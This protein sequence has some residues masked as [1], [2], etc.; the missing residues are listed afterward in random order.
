[1]A[2]DV[3]ILTLFPDSF[4]G[5]FNESI[6]Y[7]A[8]EKF[9]VNIRAVNVRD[10]ADDDRGTVD[11]RPFGGGPGMVMKPDTLY[12][13]IQSVLRPDSTLIFTTPTGRRFEQSMA[14]EFSQMSH[15]VIVCGH[16]EGMD[17]RVIDAFEHIEVSIGDFILTSGNLAAMVMVDAVARLIPGVLGCDE[18]AEQESFSEGLLEYPQYTRPREFLGQEIPPVLLSGDHKAIARWRHAQSLERT[19]IRRPDLIEKL[20]HK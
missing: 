10:F 16:Y 9:L 20:K 1:M 14:R 17:Q 11:D 13:A 4:F 7:R 5:P 15:L 2:L 19:K 12:R 8:R 3:D 18:S 6:I